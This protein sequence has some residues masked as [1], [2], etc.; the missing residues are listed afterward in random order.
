MFRDKKFLVKNGLAPS[1]RS[2][3]CFIIGYLYDVVVENNYCYDDIISNKYYEAVDYIRCHRDEFPKVYN[4][5]C[6]EKT[7]IEK[8]ASLFKDK[9]FT[10]NLSKKFDLDVERK[11]QIKDLSEIGIY[12]IYIENELIYI[13]STIQSFQERFHEHQLLLN[14]PNKWKNSLL[15]PM[16]EEAKK[17]NKQIILKPLL[18][19][20]DLKTTGTITERDVNIM[21]L[22]FI[23]YFK[24]KANC[25]GISQRYCFNKN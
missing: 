10:I 7:I 20:G 4:K 21:E 19:I 5:I 18:C 11:L 13:G 14:S 17:N 6:L 3:T 2:D 9:D 16:L 15:Y 1:S 25:K 24:P 12:G 22:A 8:F 23:S